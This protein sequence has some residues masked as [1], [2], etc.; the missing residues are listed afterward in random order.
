MWKRRIVERWKF[1]KVEKKNSG[2]VEKKKRWKTRKVE[3][4][5]SGNE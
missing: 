3:K 1:E 5:K 2:N 4:K